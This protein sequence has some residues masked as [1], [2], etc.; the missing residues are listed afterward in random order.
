MTK[1]TGKLLS[2]ARRAFAMFYMALP[3]LVFIFFVVVFWQHPNPHSN[4]F[5]KPINWTLAYSFWQ[6]LP[7]LPFLIWPVPIALWLYRH[8]PTLCK[9]IGV[10]ASILLFFFT[11]FISLFVLPGGDGRMGF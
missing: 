8:S 3:F 4:G 10:A 11:T 9:G 1:T 6:V 5:Q 2:S 7:T